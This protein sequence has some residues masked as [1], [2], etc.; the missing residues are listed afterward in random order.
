MVERPQIC[1]RGSVTQSI[2]LEFALFVHMQGVRVKLVHKFVDAECFSGG[3]GV[4]EL[5]E[6]PRSLKI[7]LVIMLSASGL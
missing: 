2:C 6:S 1:S 7:R 3:I 4:H 5:S